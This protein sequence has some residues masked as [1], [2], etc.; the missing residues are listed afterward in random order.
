MKGTI[1][2]LLNTTNK[3]VKIGNF[4]CIANAR[5]TKFV[6][7]TLLI[8]ANTLIKALINSLILI[9]ALKLKAKIL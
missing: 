3:N 2:N 8:F 6:I 4:L 7:G 1:F 9:L 5:A